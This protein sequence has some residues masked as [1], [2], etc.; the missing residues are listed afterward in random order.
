MTLKITETPRKSVPSERR[1]WLT[2]ED[3][4]SM[5][6][7]Y[8]RERGVLISDSDQTLIFDCDGYGAQNGGLTLLIKDGDLTYQRGTLGDGYRIRD[9]RK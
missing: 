3:V 5:V 6:L 9:D 1:V 4:S 7:A 8:C 2:R